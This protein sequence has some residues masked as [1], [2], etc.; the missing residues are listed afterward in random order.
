MNVTEGSRALPGDKV[1]YSSVTEGFRDMLRH[2]EWYYGN[3]EG[4]LAW[5]TMVLMYVTVGSSSMP[6]GPG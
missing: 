2:P 3:M 5:G 4:F 6:G 1:R